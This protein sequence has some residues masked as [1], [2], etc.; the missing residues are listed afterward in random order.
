[1]TPSPWW[2]RHIHDDRRPLLLQR[3]RIKHAFRQYFEV[4]GFCEVE[5]GALAVSPGNEAH[6]HA[7]VT[8]LRTP[9][10]DSRTLYLHTS[11]EFAAKKLLAAGETR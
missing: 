10:G 8:E 5:C 2:S 1:M 9:A 7:F 11:P 6:L 4:E 3:N